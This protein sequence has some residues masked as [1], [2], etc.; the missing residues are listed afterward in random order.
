[1]NK[2]LTGKRNFMSKTSPIFRY[3]FLSKIKSN[4]RIQHFVCHIFE[5]NS[6]DLRAKILIQ[7]SHLL[8]IFNSEKMIL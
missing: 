1:M 5:K 7:I 3:L 2:I 8:T 6:H 4:F